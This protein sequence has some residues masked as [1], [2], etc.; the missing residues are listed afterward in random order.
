MQRTATLLALAV[1]FIS[2][3]GVISSPLAEFAPNIMRTTYVAIIQAFLPGKFDDSPQ[4]N[5][6][7]FNKAFAAQTQYKTLRD[8]LDLHGPDCGNTL[9]NVAAKAIPSDGKMTWKNPDT[10]EGFIP[11]HTGPCEIWLDSTRVFQN[12]DCATNFPAAPE[13]RLPV[14]Y[15]KCGPNGCLLR[16][17]WLALHQPQWQVY[18]NC[19]PLQGNDQGSAPAVAPAPTTTPSS[20]PSLNGGQCSDVATG[21]DYFGNDVANVYVSGTNQD[22]VSACCSACTQKTGCKGFTINGDTCWLKSQLV[23][24]V[25]CLH[26][27]SAAFVTSTPTQAPLLPSGQCAT[28]QKEVDYYGND[29]GNRRVSGS[30]HDKVTACCSACRATSGCKGFTVNGETCWLK[31]KLD[32]AVPC[33]HCLSAAFSGA[34]PTQA[35]PLNG[36]QCANVQNEIDYYGNDIANV[37]VSGT[38]Q[39]KVSVC[40][41]ACTQTRGCKGFTINGDTCWLKSQ[42]LNAAP[43]RNCISASAGSAAQCGSIASN[44]DYYGN[45]IRS[46]PVL[47]DAMSQRTQCCNGCASTSGCVGFAINSGTCWLKN[48]L[49]NKSNTPG[50][51]SGSYTTYRL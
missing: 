38:N 46:F 23:N 45:D 24:A 16:F 48:K 10:G 33:L 26:C 12:N 27:I 29:I 36:G 28:V 34:Y 1:P 37:H 19:V 14:D 17:Y 40:C 49:A 3:H 21:V 20:A 2:G 51:V 31:S 50:V 25:P 35:P 13:A 43:C 15:T 44:T 8:L 22:K 5:V 39:D 9:P 32:V 18:K 30:S 4:T 6:A 11:S 41:S 42:L 47:G 7:N